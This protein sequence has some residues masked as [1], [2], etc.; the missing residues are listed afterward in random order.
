MDV[1]FARAWLRDVVVVVLHTHANPGANPSPSMRFPGTHARTLMNGRR[2][3][4]GCTGQG[5]RFTR[6]RSFARERVRAQHGAKQW[7]RAN[8]G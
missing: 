7:G 3:V 4:S 5:K 6:A 2:R 1:P 8:S